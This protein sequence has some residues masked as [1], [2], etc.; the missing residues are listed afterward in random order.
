PS[1]ADYDGDDYDRVKM[2][3]GLPTPTYHP[4]NTWELFSQM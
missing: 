3:L 1:P 4:M 2:M